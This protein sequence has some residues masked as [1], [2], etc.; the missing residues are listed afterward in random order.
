MLPA[1]S[2]RETKPAG[3]PRRD[4][5]VNKTQPPACST[6]ARLPQMPSGMRSFGPLLFGQLSFCLS[7]LCLLWAGP[8]LAAATDTVTNPGARSAGL[9]FWLFM[10]LALLGVAALAF[11]AGSLRER[12][13]GERALREQRGLLSQQLQLQDAYTWQT[14]SQHRLLTWRQPGQSS[15]SLPTSTAP[16]AA[17]GDGLNHKLA[18]G[19]AFK[20][21]AFRVPPAA[22]HPN[23]TQHWTLSGVPQ[24]GGDGEFAGFTGTA[25]AH[26]V[27]R[28]L[29]LQAA[30]VAPA[31]QAHAGAALLALHTGAGWRVQGFNTA[32]TQLWP[33]LRADAPWDS[34]LPLLK[35]EVPASVLDAAHKAMADPAAAASQI[36]VGNAWQLQVFAAAHMD[37]KGPMNGATGATPIDI[38][39]ASGHGLLLSQRAASAAAVAGSDA[40]TPHEGDT[41]SFTVSHDLRAP[42]RVVE[43]F[44]RIVKEDYGKLLDRVGN[45]HLD[46]VLGAAT[47]M[48]L[49]IDAL[50][51]LARLSTQPLAQQPVNLSQLASYIMDDLKRG[52]P[53]RLADIDIE[54]G[55][56]AHG[57]PTLLRL[58][59]ENLL[60]NA[61]KYSG[62]CHRAQIALR[63]VPNEGAAQATGSST[64]AHPQSSM[65]F[66]THGRPGVRAFV[67]RDNGAGFDMRSADRLFGLFQRLHS[68]SDFPGHGVG[69]ASVRR[70]VKRHGGDIWAEAEVGR[71][72]AFYF[73]LGG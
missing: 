61:W 11:Y 7:S 47:R 2:R 33:S 50:L 6:N 18:L 71:G 58:V 48:N 24:H 67:V 9:G 68:N 10:C 3:S 34:L 23:A 12:A 25:R 42:I 27:Q 26:D 1:P 21:W 45:D 40:T 22:A 15:G 32:A 16:L 20:D 55:L 19:Q 54:P 60:G 65:P 57:D 44:T 5:I 36:D 46:R 70:I 53:E 72:A 69:L 59:L 73:T 4:A 56:T 66:H 37:V 38:G 39:G 43:G 64:E 13:S 30:A 29:G 49:M 8:A 52:T 31:L 63:T 28:Q 62:R 51:T 35:A 14:D 17:L 41:F